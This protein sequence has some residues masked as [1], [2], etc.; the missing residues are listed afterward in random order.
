MAFIVFVTSV[1]QLYKVVLFI[2]LISSQ[3][4]II[5]G[6]GLKSYRLLYIYNLQP[7]EQPSS[8]MAYTEFIGRGLQIVSG[9]ISCNS[10]GP[11]PRFSVIENAF[12]M[13]STHIR[14]KHIVAQ[15]CPFHRRWPLTFHI[16]KER[17]GLPVGTEE[18][19]LLICKHST[20][21]CLSAKVL[22]HFLQPPRR[23]RFANMIQVME[24]FLFVQK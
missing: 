23:R 12:L 22:K 19:Y 2:Y 20:S 16:F 6:T 17:S 10:A 24:Y 21:V 14:I 1:H 5:R 13:S 9:N 7:C 18:G 3:N 15:M 8:S 11:L 4:K